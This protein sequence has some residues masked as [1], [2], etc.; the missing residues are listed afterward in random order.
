MKKLMIALAVVACAAASQAAQVKWIS[1]AVQKGVAVGATLDGDGSYSASG[2]NMKGNSAL[3]YVLQIFDADG[4]QVGT[5][6]K[7]TVAWAA[8]GSKFSMSGISIGDAT[9]TAGDTYSYLI[10]ITGT[11]TDLAKYVDDAW[12]YS[13]ATVE[14]VLSGTFTGKT[15]DQQISSAAVA[16]WDV[17]GA[18]AVPEPTSGLLLLLGV[19][20]LALRRR[21]A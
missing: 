10:K 19:A 12:D 9:F 8:T 11:Q 6:A 15:G 13:A 1:S 3:S 7:G 16:T 17:A 14:G 20:G 21:R 4:N 2:A 5:D 18:V